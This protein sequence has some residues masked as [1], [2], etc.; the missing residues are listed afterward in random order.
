MEKWLLVVETNCI[1]PEKENEFNEWYNNTHVPDVL[2]T[3]GFVRATRYENSNPAEGR[4]KYQALYE[5]ETDDLGKTMAELV[6][7]VDKLKE[8]GRMSELLSVV[9]GTPLR[10]IM[11][12]VDSK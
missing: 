12:P 11:G 2:K 6:E 4:G 5:I 1:Q 9:T 10:H 8:Q 3:P 7:H